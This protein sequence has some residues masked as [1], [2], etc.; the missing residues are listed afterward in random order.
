L[1]LFHPVPSHSGQTSAD[2]FMA[3]YFPLFRLCHP[4]ASSGKVKLANG[5]VLPVE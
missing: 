2:T 1:T 3:E 5:C 4:S